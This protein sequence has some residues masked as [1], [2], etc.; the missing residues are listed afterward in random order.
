[1]AIPKPNRCPFCDSTDLKNL[2]NGQGDLPYQRDY[3]DYELIVV[4]SSDMYDGPVDLIKCSN[5]HH[6][7][8]PNHLA[9]EDDTFIASL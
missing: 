2:R 9:D 3:E 6:F 1:M 7:Y 8:V 5:G 4:C